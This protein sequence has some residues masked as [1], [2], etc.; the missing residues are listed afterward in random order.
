MS[1]VEQIFSLWKIMGK[2]YT[3]VTIY[4]MFVDFLHMTQ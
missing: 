3:K 1:T 2:T 4:R